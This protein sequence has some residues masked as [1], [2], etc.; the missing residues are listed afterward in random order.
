MA[1]WSDS[2]GINPL[3]KF[4]FQVRILS[5]GD[6]GFDETFAEF[7]AKSV[8]KPTVETEV[9]EYK[10]I[11][12]I[13]KFPTIPRWNDITIRYV[14]DGTIS[15]RL[16]ELMHGEDSGESPMSSGWKA[17]AIR[18]Y[19]TAAGKSNA[20]TEN[21]QLVI[22]QLNANGNRVHTWEFKNPF[23][24]S[25]NFGELDYSDD[26]FVEVEVI[27]AYDFAYLS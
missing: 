3:R 6:D 21:F 10:L 1:F 8:N 18:K 4:A 25:I 15:E 5:T 11:N 12:Q 13:K 16:L 9:N 17:K 19:K 26:G 20:Q 14:D 27:V 24:K 22:D 7:I 23:I 2:V